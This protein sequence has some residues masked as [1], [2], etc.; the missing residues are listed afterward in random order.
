MVLY[1]Q[2]PALTTIQQSCFFHFIEVIIKYK[3]A[4]STEIEVNRE[5]SR[6][7]AGHHY[8]FV[9]TEAAKFDCCLNGQ[10]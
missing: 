5:I 4:F 1:T 9:S 10:E 8:L 7:M 2:H 3:I 6:R